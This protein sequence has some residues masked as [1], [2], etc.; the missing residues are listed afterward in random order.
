MIALEAD[1]RAEITDR[2]LSVPGVE[3]HPAEGLAEIYRLLLGVADYIE[4]SE[5]VL[6]KLGGTVNPARTLLRLPYA[7]YM[8]R[9]P[10]FHLYVCPFFKLKRY[11]RILVEMVFPANS[12]NDVLLLRGKGAQIRISGMGDLLLGDWRHGFDI[13]LDIGKVELSPGNRH[14]C[15]A[16]IA[17]EWLKAGGTRVAASFLGQGGFAPLEELLMAIRLGGAAVPAAAFR[18]LALLKLAYCRA[19][20]RRIPSHKPILG[21]EIFLVESG[22]HVDGIGKNPAN[23]EPFPPELVGLRRRLGVGKH[24][25]GRAI[26]MKLEQYGIQADSRAAANLLA[27]VRRESVRLGRGLSDAEFLGLAKKSRKWGWPAGDPD[28]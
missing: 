20:G 26:A 22:V 17:F 18:C 10:G 11:E 27:S 9:W 6:E 21:D 8:D 2:F 13:L 4:I 19:T 12:W 1:R 25:G 16:A 28:C 15:A 23:Y 7:E 24:S 3:L 5:A 14:G